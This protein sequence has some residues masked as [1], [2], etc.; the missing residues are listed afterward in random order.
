LAQQLVTELSDEEVIAS[1]EIQHEILIGELKELIKEQ[2]P[3]SQ[4]VTLN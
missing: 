4:I 1:A 2:L 3:K